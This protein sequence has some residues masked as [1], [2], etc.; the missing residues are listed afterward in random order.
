MDHFQ[1]LSSKIDS[2]QA[3]IA[4][5]GLGYVGLPLAIGFARRG[6]RV[7]GID[8]DTRKIESLLQGKDYING[9][10]ELTARLVASGLLVPERDIAKVNEVD[11]CVICVPTPLTRHREPDISYVEGVS[12]RLGQHMQPGS[13]VVLESTTYPGT[14]EEVVKPNLER[15]EIVKEVGKDYFLAFS[16]ERVDPG[17]PDYNTYNTDKVVGGVTPHCSQLTKSLYESILEGSGKV[18][19]AS[20]PRAAEME[21][22]FENIFRSVNIALVNELALL[23][24]AMGLHVWE[25][26]DLA[27]TK[28]FGFMRFDPGPGIGGHCIPLDPFYLTWK[29]REFDLTTRF[30]ELAGEI[31]SRMPYHV[32]DLAVEALGN[33]GLVGASILVLGVA[34]KRDVADARESPALKIIELLQKRGAEVSYHDPLIETVRLETGHF[35]RS[36]PLENLSGYDCVVLVTDHSSF[37]NLSSL[38]GARTLV[39][40]RG[41]TWRT[42]KASGVPTIVRLGSPNQYNTVEKVVSTPAR[43]EETLSGKA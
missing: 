22:L 21:K 41:S 2:K 4:V 1:A 32:V 11:V 27:N 10:N 16:P 9:Q 25:V 31:N 5:I 7:I 24:R 38:D 15:G 37:D 8:D 34:Y 28:P 23:C 43:G 30:I 13:L 26:L 39:D 29:A 12:A 17:N 6:F 36:K 14:T 42:Q 40:T 20:S 3:A 19:L 18:K 33:R 35:L